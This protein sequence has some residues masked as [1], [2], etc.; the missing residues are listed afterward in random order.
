[1]SAETAQAMLVAA[2]E[3][4]EEAVRAFARRVLDHWGA[5]A[6]TTTPSLW[7][8]TPAMSP[9]ERSR[10]WRAEQRL[11]KR[12]VRADTG[13]AE[14][15]GSQRIETSRRHDPSRSE[16]EIVSQNVSVRDAGAACACDLKSSSDRTEG[17]EIREDGQTVGSLDQKPT[18]SLQLLPHATETQR[19]ETNARNATKRS[20]T[21]RP[22]PRGTRIPDDWE[23][24]AA[25][26][27]WA[28]KEHRVDARAV[29]AEFVDHWRGIP[30][31][32][33]LKVDW[34]GTF[35]NRVRYLVRRGEAPLLR[36]GPGPELAR[37]SRPALTA[38]ERAESARQLGDAL[39]N[40]R[41]RNAAR[42]GK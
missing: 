31:K 13:T 41:S 23:P 18:F 42:G 3:F 39:E 2:A 26:I 20:A 28:A 32:D 1:M 12:A 15:S 24:S 8:R 17:E 36:P 33:G 7:T 25:L 14:D 34:D 5:D 38:E 10:K 30:G 35:R 19:H 40:F 37:A 9:A 6:A 27:E 22:L 21:E 11:K 29:A 4:G 16:T